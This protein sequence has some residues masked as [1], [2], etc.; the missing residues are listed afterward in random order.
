[1]TKTSNPIS[2]LEKK[3][4]RIVFLLE[5]LLAIALNDTNLDRNGIRAH[6]GVD[7]AKVNRMLNGVQ[8]GN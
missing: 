5:H 4:D 8:K 1:M 6:L 7:K 3:L 2:S